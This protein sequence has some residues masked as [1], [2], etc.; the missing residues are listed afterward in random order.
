MRSAAAST[1]SITSSIRVISRWIESRSI[2]VMNVLCSA[3]TQRW[4]IVSVS[5]SMSEI[6]R[7]F[8]GMF[9]PVVTSDR[10]S[11]VPSI[12]SAAC[13][14]KKSKKLVSRGKNRPNMQPPTQACNMAAT[15]TSP[16]GAAQSYAGANTRPARRSRSSSGCAIATDGVSTP[17]GEVSG[18]RARHSAASP[19]IFEV[20]P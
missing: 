2:G 1:K 4:V 8:A 10:N 11:F 13:C 5:C 12:V 3:S 6:R 16:T 14:S 17:P 18:S 20:E 9:A 15:A 19:S 7:H